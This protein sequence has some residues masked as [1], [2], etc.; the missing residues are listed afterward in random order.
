MANK[1]ERT[2]SQFISHLDSS[3]WDSIAIKAVEKMA[4]HKLKHESVRMFTDFTS[5]NSKNKETSRPIKRI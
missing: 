5:M 4:P 3:V 2:V 1:T